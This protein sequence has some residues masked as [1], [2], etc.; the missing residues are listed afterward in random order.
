MTSLQPTLSF[1]APPL[2]EVAFSLQFEPMKGFH[3]GHIGLVWNA[4]RSRYPVVETAEEVPQQ[5]EKFGVISRKVPPSFEL[6]EK[7]PVPRVLFI[8]EDKQYVIQI[9]KDRF[10][11]NWRKL[12]DENLRYPRYPAIKKMVLDEFA[13]FSEFLAV[14][15]LESPSFTQV[16]V[17]YVNHIDAS[18]PIEHVF[19]DVVVE[20]RFPS[21]LKLEAFTVNLKQLIMRD[22]ESVG[23]L[24]TVI[25]KANRVTDGKDLYVF[26]FTARVHPKEPSL[27]GVIGAMD[28][29]REEINNAFVNMT[30]TAMHNEWN[31]EES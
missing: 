25:E 4:F 29:M 26:K 23:R 13:V 16:E 10:I 14:N 22:T 20:S 3:I 15:G 6:L 2:E 9:Q 28:I 7:M 19:K 24:Y 12:F 21:T 31:R 11:F 17:T 5:I 8:G 1:E 27:A 30:T 18:R